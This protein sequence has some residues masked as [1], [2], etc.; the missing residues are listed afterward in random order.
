MNLG[1]MFI[2]ACMAEGSVSALLQFGTVEHLFK[3]SEKDL[4]EFV[5]GFVKKHAK[6]PSKET[7]T[8]HTGEVLGSVPEPPS[9]YHELLLQRH[10]ELT[11]KNSMKSA[12]DHLSTGSKDPHKAMEVLSEGLMS[13]VLRKNSALIHDFRDAYSLIM[14][15]LAKKMAG[16][17]G[18]GLQFG[19]PTLDEMSNGFTKGD[20]VSF[21][22]RPGMGKTWQMLYSALHGWAAPVKAGKPEESQS[23]IFVSMEMDVLSITQRLIAM[24]ATVPVGKIKSAALTTVQATKLKTG[25]TQIK[26]FPKPFYVIDGNLASTVEELWMYARQLRPEGMFI[27]GGYLLQHPSERDRFRRVAENCDL[28]KRELAP[29]CPTCVSWQF[30]RDASKKQKQNKG[31]DNKVTIDD[32]GY[33]DAIGQHST[34][35]LGTFEEESVETIQSRLIDILKGRHGEIGRFRTH[36]DFQKMDFSEVV[37][38]SVDDLQYV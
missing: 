25:L 28:I 2:A 5:T 11:L 27:D 15:D 34:C 4:Y 14:A 1:Q 23:R 30:S 8:T 29:L 24:H 37:E 18:Y 6:L 7:I 21:V 32:I 3:A 35:V 31:G 10:I 9:Y 36:W 22:G 26:G 33:S 13:L 38:E 16:P 17:D 20:L 12:M 19:W